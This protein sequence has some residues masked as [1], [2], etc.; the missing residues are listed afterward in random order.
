[1]RLAPDHTIHDHESRGWDSTPSTLD[2]E[3][4]S[5]TFTTAPLLLAEKRGSSLY[6]FLKAAFKTEL[7][8]DIRDK[9]LIL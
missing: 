5:L 8:L 6:S 3:V 9:R 4:E 1:M 7:F 2:L